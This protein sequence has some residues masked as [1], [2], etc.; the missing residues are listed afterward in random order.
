[1]AFLSDEVHRHLAVNVVYTPEGADRGVR[2]QRSRF[3]MED[4]EPP[5]AVVSGVEEAH[6]EFG[7]AV[8]VHVLH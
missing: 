6:H 7:L 1:M 5:A 2:A 3:R 4:F 8:G